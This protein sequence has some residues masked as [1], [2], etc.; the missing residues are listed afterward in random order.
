MLAAIIDTAMYKKYRH[1]CNLEKLKFKLYPTCLAP[2]RMSGAVHK[3]KKYSSIIIRI[4]HS[5]ILSEKSTNILGNLY[6]V[7]VIRIC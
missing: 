2:V 3:I 7:S 6:G 5:Q 1:K 4:S